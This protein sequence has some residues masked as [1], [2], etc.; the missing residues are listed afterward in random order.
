[1]NSRSAT[2]VD[3]LR[4]ETPRDEWWQFS[5]HKEQNEIGLK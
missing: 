2:F 3:R 4:P 1:M 5:K